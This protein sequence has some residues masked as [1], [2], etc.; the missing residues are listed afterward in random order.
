MRFSAQ[1]RDA[2][3]QYRRVEDDVA[4]VRDRSDAERKLALVNSRRQL[5]EQIGQLGPV[6]ETDADL[7]S[8]PDKQKEISR[9]FAAMR[10]SLALHQA[11][12][13]AVKIDEDPA[14]YRESS[15]GVKA[16]SD[17]FWSW[18]HTNLGLRRDQLGA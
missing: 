7:A 5:S 18:W 9:L 3:G 1:L 2:L 6:I 14:A 17:A 10:Y 4:A 13:P 11:N 15:L 12:W 8:N 16:K